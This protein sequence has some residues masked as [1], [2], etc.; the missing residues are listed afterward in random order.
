MCEKPTHSQ[1]RRC[2]RR[3]IR[4]PQ[5]S[6]ATQEPEQSR[7]DGEGHQESEDCVLRD[8]HDGAE[9]FRGLSSRKVHEKVQKGLLEQQH[10]RHDGGAR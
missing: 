6:R 3:G 5:L 2:P 1:Q 4:I 9:T 10:A 7:G 8:A